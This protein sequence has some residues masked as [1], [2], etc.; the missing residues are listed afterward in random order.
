MNGR[1]LLDTNIVIAL[2]A[3]DSAITSNLQNAQEVFV[4]SIVV[5]ELYYGAQRSG[6][7]KQN[8]AQIDS[9]SVAN[10]ILACDSTTASV[11]GTT[12]NTLP[13]KGRP[14][15]ENDIWIAAIALQHNLTLVT[16]D[17][18]LKEVDGLQ[19]Y[20][21]RVKNGHFFSGQMFISNPCRV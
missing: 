16:R 1:Y 11:Y 19:I 12:K 6:K 7:M 9:F 20:C 17:A 15:P 8:I 18:H 2:F 14:I 21:E 4:P 3:N 5:G 10:T 13:K